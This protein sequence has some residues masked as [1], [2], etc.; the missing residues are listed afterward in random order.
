MGVIVAIIALA[1]CCSCGNDEAA[2]AQ[3]ADLEASLSSPDRLT[4]FEAI[5][6]MKRRCPPPREI[7]GLFQATLL[8]EDV[9]QLY[10]ASYILAGYPRDEDTV[11][12]AKRLVQDNGAPR[13]VAVA[14]V[15]LQQH[16]PAAFAAY[17]K[18]KEKLEDVPPP[19]RQLLHSS[20]PIV[21]LTK[22]YEGQVIT[23]WLGWQPPPESPHTPNPWRGKI[24]ELSAADRGMRFIQKLLEAIPED[25][26]TDPAII[27]IMAE[28][29]SWI[30]G[31]FLLEAYRKDPRSDTAVAI[32]CALSPELIETIFVSLSEHELRQLLR[33]VLGTRWEQVRDKDKDKLQGYMMENVMEIKLEC[34]NRSRSAGR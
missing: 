15:Y 33:S 9:D 30:T 27:S 2:S 8:L 20:D 31:P 1:C 26:R 24:L 11:A 6:E 32:G 19:V 16:G 18:S 3:S 25:R 17:F 29:G 10:A 12:I 13:A 22:Q 5:E 4:R 28:I 7:S 23:D 34:V 14:L 21:N